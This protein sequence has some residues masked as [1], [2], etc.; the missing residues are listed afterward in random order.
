MGSSKQSVICWLNLVDANSGTHGVEILPGMHQAGLLP[1]KQ[2]QSAY[3]L[4]EDVTRDVDSLVPRIFAGDLLLMSSFLPHRTHVNP[5]FSD[6]KLS[7]SQ[8]FDDLS[9]SEWAKR[10]YRNAYGIH[11]NRRLYLE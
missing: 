3:V 6:W 5:S 11:V 7:I 1:G 2:T 8:R 9:D 4:D 10:G